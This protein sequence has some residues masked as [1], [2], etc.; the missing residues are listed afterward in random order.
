MERVHAFITKCS[1][2][3]RKHYVIFKSTLIPPNF[4]KFLTYKKSTSNSI[5]TSARVRVVESLESQSRARVA[6]S[7]ESLES[8]I[9]ICF[10]VVESI[11]R[12]RMSSGEY[13][14][15]CVL[16]VSIVSVLS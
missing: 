7:S 3:Q 11:Y 2:C 15:C 13:D 14:S 16:G 8:L 10:G 5:I 6:Y 1:K 12:A 4:R 9:S